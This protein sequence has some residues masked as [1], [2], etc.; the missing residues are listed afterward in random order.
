MQ[1]AE[2]PHDFCISLE[3]EILSPMSLIG[4]ERNASLLQLANAFIGISCNTRSA[5][6][7]DKYK[8]KNQQSRHTY[9]IDNIYL[10]SLPFSTYF[11]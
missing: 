5:E 3:F 2:L 10:L 1:F 11:C 9:V 6:T 8:G 7:Y 4:T